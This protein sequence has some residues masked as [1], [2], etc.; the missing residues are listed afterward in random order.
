[1]SYKL[2]P[3][4]LDIAALTGLSAALI[5]SHYANNY[6]GAVKRLNAI[7]EQLGSG[8]SASGTVSRFTM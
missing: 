1:M 8:L 7:Q 6:G 2:L 5:Q 4:P 3:L